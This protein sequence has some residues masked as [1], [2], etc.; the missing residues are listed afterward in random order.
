MKQSKDL[1]TTTGLLSHLGDTMLAL[2]LKTIDVEVAKAQAN[3]VKQS[4]NLF[5]Y[6]LDKKK[7][8]L[9]LKTENTNNQI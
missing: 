4:N 8:E 1:T 2:E 7:F 5:R 3:L 6:E 9:K